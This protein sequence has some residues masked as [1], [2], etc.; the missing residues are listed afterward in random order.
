MLQG[1][2]GIRPSY[3]AKGIFVS[4]AMQECRHHWFSWLFSYS[5]SPL[6][7]QEDQGPNVSLCLSYRQKQEW[8]GSKTRR[9]NV[10]ESVW[11]EQ[12]VVLTHGR[13]LVSSTGKREEQCDD[14]DRNMKREREEVKVTL[15]GLLILSLSVYNGLAALRAK[16]NCIQYALTYWPGIQMSSAS[17][18]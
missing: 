12:N 2:H 3:T 13:S 6:K 8:R 16:M 1:L 14:L 9:R 15:V 7:L 10:S 17:G 18:K 4:V 11:R 5:Y